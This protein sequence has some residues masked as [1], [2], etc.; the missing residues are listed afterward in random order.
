MDKTP[1]RAHFSLMLGVKTQATPFKFR[2]AFCAERKAFSQQT[3]EN[4]S[5]LSWDSLSQILDDTQSTV[6]NKTRKLKMRNS[7]KVQEHV[8]KDEWK[9][10]RRLSKSIDCVFLK[11]FKNQEKGVVKRKTDTC[12]PHIMSTICVRFQLICCSMPTEG[13]D[14]NVFFHRSQCSNWKWGLSFAQ[15]GITRQ[16][17]KHGKGYGAAVK[18]HSI[19]EGML[20]ML[21]TKY[22]QNIHAHSLNVID[23]RKHVTNKDKAEKVTTTDWMNLFWFSID[24][25]R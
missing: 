5:Q 9:A 1:V 4:F 23:G 25:P 24:K 16:V 11:A 3:R 15:L 17:R 6:C 10:V 20:N 12:V 19:R 18:A 22:E 13:K 2:S 21:M 8:Q 7:T 14:S